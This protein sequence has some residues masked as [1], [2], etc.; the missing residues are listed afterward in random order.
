M[1]PVISKVVIFGATGNT[2]LTT[3]E[4]ALKKAQYLRK[5]LRNF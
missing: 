5:Y 3:V 4:N 1:A 2:G